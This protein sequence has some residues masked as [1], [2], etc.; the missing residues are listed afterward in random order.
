[1]SPKWSVLEPRQQIAV[2]AIVAVI[3]AVVVSALLLQLHAGERQMRQGVQQRL[4]ELAQVQALAQQYQ[5][6]HV[7]G[8]PAGDLIDLVGIVSSGL[9]D[10][11]LQPTRLQQNSA[12]ELQVRIDAA[13]YDQVIA[14]LARLEQNPAVVLIRVTL[15]QGPNGAV[16]VNL[17]LHKRL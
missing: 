4:T 5:A 8:Q 11:G 16:S 15:T 7:N 17:S 12:D 13:P 3:A 10:A 2:A 9:K 14:A 6:H 1:M